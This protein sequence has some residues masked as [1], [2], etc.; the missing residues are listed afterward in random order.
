MLK[1]N[2]TSDPPPFIQQKRKQTPVSKPPENPDEIYEEDF[3]EFVE[4]IPPPK[5]EKRSSSH[6][7]SQKKPDYSLETL[8]KD[9]ELENAVA[10]KREEEIP[11]VP[12]IPSAVKTTVSEYI[13]PVIFNKQQHRNKNISEYVKLE[14]ES[15]SIF[16]LL[17]FTQYD[18]L[19]TKVNKGD[20]KNSSTQ[21]NENRIEKDA[22]TNE[23]LVKEISTQWPGDLAG[24]LDSGMQNS[25]INKFLTKVSPMMEILL[26][27]NLSDKPSKVNIKKAEASAGEILSQ[28]EIPGIEFLKSRFPDASFQVKDLIFFPTKKNFLC[29]LY[30][31]DKQG[32]LIAV[33]DI[34][35]ISK[36]NRLLYSVNEITSIC[37]S[38]SKEHI[39]IAGNTIG[40]LELW[41]LREPGS[42]HEVYKIDEKKKTSIRYPTYCTD[43]LEIYTHE[44]KILK[45]IE[46]PATKGEN[47]SILVS[48][49]EG[50]IVTWTVIEM[51]NSDLDVMDFGL[52]IGGRVK[53]VK[54]HRTS[55]R[56]IFPRNKTSA[57]TALALDL[58]DGQ[59]F[60]YAS[61]N[62][63][64]Y[65][66][67]F[68]ME[69]S[70]SLFIK[71]TSEISSINFASYNSYQYFL[72][73]FSCGSVSL[74]D[75]NYSKA[76]CN[77]IEAV[78]GI[79]K[80][81]WDVSGKCGFFTL[82]K[83]QTVG[84]WDLKKGSY[85]PLCT[86][87]IDTPPWAAVDWILPE[88]S[89]HSM[90]VAVASS[91]GIRVINLR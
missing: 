60:L 4:E 50:N 84:V 71:T 78:G 38:S 68:G 13:D 49:S 69:T 18:T 1:L 81:G 23:I 28:S 14:K 26:E 54:S 6:A 29:A 52:R 35:N 10:L 2:E 55:I 37:M 87:K 8:K 19:V 11:D 70:P 77:W 20:L 41:D 22:Q 12:I 72:A 63:I 74:F 61:P 27:E 51:M 5:P 56:E 66:N 90:I 30:D 25:S 36:P 91:G 62:A 59:K 58:S 65:G 7:R 79:I 33:W 31:L 80:I 21:F 34:Q 86:I 42:A 44:G 85:G 73:G 24:N 88:S 16:E 75:K 48:D 46:F 89:K 47:F 39:I 17:P 82:D 40:S 76:I 83:N 57:C 53:L 67:R 15:F 43:S 45:I 9:I 32:S 3:E 64:C